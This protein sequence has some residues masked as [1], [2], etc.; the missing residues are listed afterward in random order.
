M[1]SRLRHRGPDGHGFHVEGPVA[2]AHQRLALI[3]LCTGG[4]PMANA[5]ESVWVTYNG[6]LYNY[7]E[8]RDE[9]KAKGHLFRTA[10]DTEVIVQAWIEWGEACVERFRGM[11]AFAIADYRRRVLFLARDQLGIK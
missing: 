1:A 4:Q 8:L 10:S 9:L 3:D 7:R 2:L 5:E 6:E 11:F